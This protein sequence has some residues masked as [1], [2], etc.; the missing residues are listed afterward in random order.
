MKFSVI[1]P[2][3]N[4]EKYI[5]KLLDSLVKQTFNYEDFEVIIVD[6]CSQDRT[7]EIAN[8]Y[9]T[10]LNL[11]TYKLDS[12]SGGP[13]R[14]RNEALKYARGEYIFFLDS[15]DSIASETLENVDKFVKENNADTILVKLEGV[16]GRSA[17]KSM[18]KETK[19]EVDLVDSRILFTLSATK[20]FK[21]SLLKDNNIWFPENLKSAEDQIFT[22]KAYLKSKKISILADQSYYFI[23]KR[24]GEHMSEAYV[25]P[26]KF[27]NVMSLIIEEILKSDKKEKY[28]ILSLFLKREFTVSKTK[29]FSL[30]IKDDLVE[31]WMEAFGGFLELIPERVYDLLEPSFIPLIKYGKNRDF[32]MYKIIEKSYKEN[33]FNDIRIKD[34][35][36]W[37]K[38][39]E[40]SPYF[41]VSNLDMPSIKMEKFEMNY[42]KLTIDIYLWNSL[43]QKSK[44]SSQYY[45][46]LKSRDKAN[47]IY[48]PFKLQK[49][50]IF[51]FILDIDDSASFLV[52]DKI[53]DLFFLIETNG[54]YVERRLGN[55]RNNY[56]YN[57]GTSLQFEYDDINYRLTPYFTKGFDNLSLIIKS[58]HTSKMFEVKYIDSNNCELVSKSLPFILN[59]GVLFIKNKN[60]LISGYIYEGEKYKD[61]V[62]T[63]RLQFNKKVR[64]KWMENNVNTIITSVIMRK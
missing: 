34:N 19:S 38:F 13:G 3:Y 21:A 26:T 39:T 14:P 35:K 40:E 7:L 41:D 10:K 45:L 30:R 8:D 24:E 57:E 29:N 32:T 59:E 63:Y 64:K 25:S 36:I 12:N 11:S 23:N 61:S 60:K 51:R 44:N 48:I 47:V 58:I 33:T 43:V 5:G 31:E 55:N 42:Q 56:I 49:N 17:P 37:A 52:K 9:K 54:Y 20:F 28:K 53:W 22:I 46:K 4:S 16:N 6:D 15:D 1:V 18:Y 50:N 62:L 2:S 27:Y